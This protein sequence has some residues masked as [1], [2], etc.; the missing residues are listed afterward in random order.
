MLVTVCVT[1]A[2]EMVVIIT[3]VTGSTVDSVVDSVVLE[4]SDDGVVLDCEDVCEQDA[5]S[6]RVMRQ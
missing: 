1:T 5:L 6:A 2:P 3:L 4:L